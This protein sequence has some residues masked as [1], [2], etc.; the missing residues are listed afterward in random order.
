MSIVRVD[1]NPFMLK[2]AR[3]KSGYKIDM[4]PKK[5]RK[6]VSS[7]E[8]GEIKPTW[9]QVRD[10]GKLYK[11]PSA[12]FLLNEPPKE[13]SKD[14]IIDFRHFSPE[15]S[16]KSPALCNEIRRCN[17]RREIFLDILQK[18]GIHIP[19]FKTF[20]DEYKNYKEFAQFIRE[21]LGI[22][23]EEQ[24]SWTN[25][26]KS[27][28]LNN[29]KSSIENLNVLIFESQKVEEDETWG[30]CL[31]KDK[32]PVICLNGKIKFN[33]RVFTLIHE[34]VHLLLKKS[35]LCD[36]KNLNK[37]D[38]Q[39]EVFCNKVAGEVLVPEKYL[40]DEIDGLKD[41]NEKEWD[42]KELYDLA[43]KF[44]VSKEVVLVRLLKLNRTTEEF[45]LLKREQWKKFYKENDENNKKSGGNFDRNLLKYNGNLFTKTIL[46]AYRNDLIASTEFS[47]YMGGLQLFH[48][49]ILENMMENAGKT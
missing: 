19:L 15:R 49:D 18:S 41:L 12:F 36:L 8:S 4:L 21:I 39:E 14:H 27:Q 6:N 30:F 28:A 46:S 48:A 11:R 3:E 7:W 22:T 13:E 17:Y 32:F 40:K 31:S 42:E 29:W 5:I 24:F 10:L 38:D 35:A 33:G 34:F 9:N 45:Y 37:I 47:E 2:W 43:S 26:P 25:Y 23:I 1:V 20:N 16:E 44:S